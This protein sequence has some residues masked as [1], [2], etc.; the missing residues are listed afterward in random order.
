MESERLRAQSTRSYFKFTQSEIP[1]VLRLM[2][3]LSLGNKVWLLLRINTPESLF[4][5][6]TFFLLGLLV[7]N[8]TCLGAEPVQFVQH[9]LQYQEHVLHVQMCYCWC[10]RIQQADDSSPTRHGAG[11]SAG[12][13]SWKL[14]AAD[15][16]SVSS[17]WRC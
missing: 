10:Y 16:H 1:F 5:L 2:I 4:M 15:R 3:K 8:R 13:S 6:P 7:G 14:E 17:L 12:Q 9:V 11:G